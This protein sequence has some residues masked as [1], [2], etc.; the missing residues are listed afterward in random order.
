VLTKVDNIQWT[1]TD[2][3]MKGIDAQLPTSPAIDALLVPLTR[4]GMP[5]VFVV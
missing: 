5:A 1:V 3:G 2:T 4:Y